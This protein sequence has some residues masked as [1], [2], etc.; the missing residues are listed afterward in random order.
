M[1]LYN[2]V[3]E[4]KILHSKVLVKPF[5]AIRELCLNLIG[6]IANGKLL[7]DNKFL[8]LHINNSDN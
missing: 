1:P 2:S 3:S 6:L 8:K 4:S 5:T 7:I